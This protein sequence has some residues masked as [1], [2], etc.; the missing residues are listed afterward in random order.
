M[1]A[2][3]LLEKVAENG[4]AAEYEIAS[5]YEKPTS[6]GEAAE[7]D[8]SLEVDV[9]SRPDSVERARAG[10]AL[11][12]RTA[13]AAPKP[14]TEFP[15][16]FYKGVVGKALDMVPLEPST[17]TGLQQVNAVVS[18]SFAGRSLAALTGLGRGPLL[19]IA[20][21]LWGIFSAQKISAGQSGASNQLAQNTSAATVD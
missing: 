6:P 14:P 3:D 15:D 8:L 20:G 21:L 13:T 12:E 17:R 18:N 2:V 5:A 11:Y 9:R 16:L 1:S 10:L 19:I 4:N 7:G